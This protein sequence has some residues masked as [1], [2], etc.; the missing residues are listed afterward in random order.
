[1]LIAFDLVSVTHALPRALHFGELSE[2]LP[3]VRRLSGGCRPL[4]RWTLAQTCRHLADSFSGSMDGF[5]VQEH[6]LMRTLFGRAALLDVFRTGKIGSGFTVTERLNPPPDVD[7]DAAIVALDQAL[8]RFESHTG[9]LH[10]HPFFGELDRAEW[11]RL[12]C[13]HSAHHLRRL[14]PDSRT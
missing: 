1:M 10:F 5:G 6:R 9:P 8:R 3:E 14:I 12:H 4:G 2:I 11:T 7:L 13:I